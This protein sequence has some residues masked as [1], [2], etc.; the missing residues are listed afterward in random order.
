MTLGGMNEK[1]G[2]AQIGTA[3]NKLSIPISNHNN[4]FTS[5]YQEN[6]LNQ[7]DVFEQTNLSLTSQHNKSLFETG[8][9]DLVSKDTH[10]NNTLHA[11]HA[12]NHTLLAGSGYGGAV[13]SPG[14]SF[15]GNADSRLKTADSAMVNMKRR[16]HNPHPSVN[17]K[18]I[19]TSIIQDG[20]D[21][22]GTSIDQ[23]LKNSRNTHRVQQ[24]FGPG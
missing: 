13:P 7:I 4:F 3:R 24:S 21:T 2:T 23:P 20:S 22:R 18:A 17:M 16:Q 14:D 10:K 12:A 11:G 6:L 8:P 15:L 5:K 1:P 19:I 9:F